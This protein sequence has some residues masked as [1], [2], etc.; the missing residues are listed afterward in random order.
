M[1]TPTRIVIAYASVGSG[2]R[3]AAESV[4]HEITAL[5]GDAV[6]ME[7]LDVLDAAASRIDGARA[8]SPA[9]K[10]LATAFDSAAAWSPLG[11]LGLTLAASLQPAVAR[12][13]ERAL[14]D[15]Q[16]AVVVCTHAWPATVVA[17]L[18][19]RARLRTKLVCVATGF[20]A[21][22][23]WPRDQ[24]DLMCVA[25]EA[26]AAHAAQRLP[27]T[28]VAV[29]G[30][31]VRPQ[32]TLEYDRRAAREHF[33][34][35][36]ESRLILVLAG[37]SSPDTYAHLKPA[38]EVAMPALASMPGTA[39][40]VMTGDDAG[41]ADALRSRASGFG[42]GNVHVLGYTDYVA[43]LMAAADLAIAK[44]GGLVCAE[45]IASGLP[46]VLVGPATGQD[47]ANADA[48]VGAGA[49]VYTDDPRLLA[50]TARTAAF[51]PKRLARM[52]VASESAARPFASVDVAHRVLALV[53]IEPEHATTDAPGRSE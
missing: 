43:P 52:R 32:F 8:T 45:C 29:T 20:S 53:G 24:I 46:L 12:P 31:P 13:F 42:T 1:A 47:R 30:I 36:A 25:D 40:A 39:L 5:A 6:S 44:P 33:G 35:P 22:P 26:S 50:E 7:V 19:R 27:D 48:L 3:I 23:M 15:A 14:V 21:H 34:L 37:A 10:R 4:A 17:R 38:F 28:P 51:K 18:I 49:A 2:H 16:P 9:A 41:Y 11:R